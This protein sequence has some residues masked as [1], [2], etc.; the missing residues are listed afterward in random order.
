[1]NFQ[2]P[3]GLLQHCK[4][5]IKIIWIFEKFNNGNNNNHNFYFLFFVFITNFIFRKF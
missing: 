5:T 2:Q 3:Q 1:M 4:T